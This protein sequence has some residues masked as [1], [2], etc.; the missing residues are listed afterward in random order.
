MLRNQFLCALDRR[1]C[2]GERDD[3]D[4]RHHVAFGH[5]GAIIE[6]GIGDCRVDRVKGINERFIGS[7]QSRVCSV[8]I[9]AAGRRR[10]GLNA[11]PSESRSYTTGS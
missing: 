10:L 3:L 9:D 1:S 4:G 6:T 7:E 11:D 8:E 5:H 2:N